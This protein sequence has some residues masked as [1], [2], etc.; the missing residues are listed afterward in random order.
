MPDFLPPATANL[1]QKAEDLAT[2]LIKLRDD[3]SLSPAARAAA[4]REASKKAGIFSL[5]RDNAPALDLLV[6]RET[7]A[8]KGVSHL[9]GIWGSDAGTLAGVQGKLKET[10]L[11]PLL[12][13]EKR[14]GFAFTEP[15]GAPRHSWA[16]VDGDSLI[17]NGQ[18][19]YVTGGADA[20]FLAAL[21]E[22]E[23]Q[24]PSMVVIDTNLPGVQIIRRFSSLDGSHHAAFQFTDV[25]VPSYH[26]IGKPGQ[27]M[28]RALSKISQVRRAVAA[29]C[30]GTMLFIL[31]L[32]TSELKRP[33]RAGPLGKFDRVRLRFGHMRILTFA[34]RATVYRAARLADSGDDAINES[35]AAKVFCTETAGEICD[36]AIQL[37]GGESLVVGHP[38]EAALRRLRVLR[39]A[40]GESDTLRAN[41]SK[42][43]LE[44]QKGR[45]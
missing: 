36:M 6:V 20:D 4:V 18:K 8:A 44:R 12:D 35:I 3:E 21:I 7:L 40:E 9:H 31:D 33:R 43:F 23:G 10:H 45:L 27:G 2:Q 19:S 37:L 14:A 22:I 13:G 42:G 24:G 30:V 39:L 1:K 34:A 16:K 32:V 11:Q 17:I 38:L 28:T 41:L 29:D 25:R 26:A 15:A 5:A